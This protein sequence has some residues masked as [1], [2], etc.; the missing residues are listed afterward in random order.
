[1]KFSGGKFLKSKKLQQQENISAATRFP[2][3]NHDMPKNCY[4]KKI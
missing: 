4:T 1:M 2:E 3:K